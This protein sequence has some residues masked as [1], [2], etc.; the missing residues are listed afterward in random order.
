[1]I[2][3]LQSLCL[4]ALANGMA[5][6]VLCASPM[7]ANGSQTINIVLD[8][9]AEKKRLMHKGSGGRIHW[10][11]DVI[12]AQGSTLRT[13]SLCLIRSNA[14]H[15]VALG[16]FVKCTYPKC[17]VMLKSPET[18]HKL[19]A[20]RHIEEVWFIQGM[21]ASRMDQIGCLMKFDPAWGV[22]ITCR[23]TLVVRSS[24]V[25]VLILVLGWFLWLVL[26]FCG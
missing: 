10:T 9:A 19:L 21:P 22:P 8:V 17:T 2:P 14:K 11:L 12:S 4:N 26:F 15:R 6:D 23:E 13:G 7:D 25:P 3:S 18:E 24:P 5:W 16:W 1:M 20:L